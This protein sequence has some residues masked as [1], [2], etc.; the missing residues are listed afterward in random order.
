MLTLL[1]TSIYQYYPINYDNHS[2]LKCQF[3]GENGYVLHE[4]SLYHILNFFI[5]L[6]LF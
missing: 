6:Q 3:L 5:Y 1:N 4:N 2:I